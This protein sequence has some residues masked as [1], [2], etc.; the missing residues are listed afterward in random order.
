MNVASMI[1]LLVFSSCKTQKDNR[2]D[3]EKSD[4]YFLQASNLIKSND[5]EEALPL[6]QEAVQLDQKNSTKWA[7]LGN[8]ELL[9][10]KDGDALRH[11]SKAINLLPSL[12]SQSEDEILRMF[13]NLKIAADK[14]GSHPI[15]LAPWVN[16]PY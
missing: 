4:T 2:T 15:N 12:P 10:G 8:C 5:Y 7:A 3:Q 9:L 14:L 1:G 16:M 11:I 6:L 13:A